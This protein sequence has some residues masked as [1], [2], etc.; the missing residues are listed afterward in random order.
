M[1]SRI[2]V[3][4]MICATTGFL[5]GWM[6][7]PGSVLTAPAVAGSIKPNRASQ[8]TTE[9]KETESP[10]VREEESNVENEDAT[11]QPGYAMANLEERDRTIQRYRRRFESQLSEWTAA[12]NLTPAQQEKLSKAIRDELALIES[13]WGDGGFDPSTELAAQLDGSALEAQASKLLADNQQAPFEQWQREQQAQ[14]Q[15]ASAI[16]SLSSLQSA[17]RMSTA[18]RHLVVE[19]L[20]KMAAEDE[21]SLPPPPAGQA[22]TGFLQE[23]SAKLSEGG[24]LKS[25]VATVAKERI[26]RQTGALKDLLSASQQED[27]RLYLEERQQTWLRS[28]PTFDGLITPSPAP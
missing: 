12:L 10:R 13:N 8:R 23:I 26:T 7:H 1:K 16:T 4:G 5:F 3:V 20:T 14:Q 22:D 24:D 21:T 28:Q 27:Y 11:D 15:E 2:F 18:Q 9:S 17:V 6:M 25:L 19:R